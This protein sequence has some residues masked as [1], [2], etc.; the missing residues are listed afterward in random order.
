MGITDEGPIVRT[1]LAVP[2]IDPVQ[3]YSYAAS[4]MAEFLKKAFTGWFSITVMGSVAALRYRS[5][6]LH[7]TRVAKGS[8]PRRSR[9]VSFK[10]DVV[11]IVTHE[12]QHCGGQSR[13]NERRAH[14]PIQFMCVSDRLRAA[15]SGP[16]SARHPKSAH[17]RCEAHF[18]APLRSFPNRAR[19]T[20]DANCL[21]YLHTRRIVA[22]AGALGSGF[23]DLVWMVGH[24]APPGKCGS[25]H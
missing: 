23:V 15:A 19:D 8:F 1:V 6:V 4:A 10:K 5:L 2:F 7:G 11:Q 12:G 9:T 25:G 13:E 20:T 24:F 3:S 16:W 22:K 21:E 18:P 17:G 14:G